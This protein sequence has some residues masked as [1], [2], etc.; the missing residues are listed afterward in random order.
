LEAGIAEIKKSLTDLE[1]LTF[2]KDKV[3]PH[4][5]CLDETDHKI[6]D[7]LLHYKGATTPELADCLK[8]N[9]WYVLGRLRK[10]QKRSKTQ[11][12]KSII[13]YY[14][15]ERQ[16]KKKAWWLIKEIAEA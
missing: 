9:R 2:D 12:G 5:F 14:A 15:A 4:A 3:N 8:S 6:M 16:G 13:E 7:Y 1:V 10:L 11:L